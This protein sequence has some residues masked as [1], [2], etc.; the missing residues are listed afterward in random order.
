MIEPDKR[1]KVLDAHEWW[2]DLLGYFIFVG[3]GC[4]II[5]LTKYFKNKDDA[6]ETLGVIALLVACSWLFLFITKIKK[7]IINKLSNRK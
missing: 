1:K 6:F 4:F 3:L 2:L 5:S 7:Y